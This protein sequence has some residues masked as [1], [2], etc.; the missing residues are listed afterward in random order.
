M[1]RVLLAVAVASVLSAPAAIADTSRPTGETARLDEF[2][3]D[4]HPVMLAALQ[5]PNVGH[6]AIAQ[7]DLPPAVEQVPAK[8]TFDWEGVLGEGVVA[9][10]GAIALALWRRATLTDERRK[11]ILTF[12]DMAYGVVNEVARR[13]ANTVDDKAALGLRHVLDL[14]A[15]NGQK[16]LTPGETATVRSLFDANH[17]NEAKRLEAVAAAAPKV[18]NI[19]TQPAP[20]SP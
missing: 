18:V 6:T 19:G 17:G 10:I 11:L 8:K 13:S 20:A 7:A 14:L 1:R 4:D 12:G 3:R 5:L 9:A 2:R 16:P 15:A